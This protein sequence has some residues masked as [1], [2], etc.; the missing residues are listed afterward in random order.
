[1][2]TNYAART[3]EEMR[4]VLMSPDEP[5]P[6]LHYHMVRGGTQKTNIT[7]WEPGTVGGEYIK[8]YGHY[9]VGDLEETYTVLQGEGVIILQERAV[10][11][12][13][14]PLDDE[15]ASFRA[16]RVR[17]GDKVHIP[18]NTGHLAVN[19]GTVWLVTSDDSPVNF[20]EPQAVSFPGHADYAP[21]K[22]L[23]GA[24]YYVVEANGTPTLV[25]NPLYKK[26]PDAHIT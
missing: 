23:R 22:S 4:D 13:G 11:A 12:E 3:H 8:S 15:I 25:R 17:A 16:I 20:G 14:V 7:I 24:A 21:F 10:S 19:T 5:G 1:M 26:M 6:A 9:H 2:S 18:K